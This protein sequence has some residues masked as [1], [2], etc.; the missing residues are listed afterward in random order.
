[1]RRVFLCAALALGVL[2]PA[3]AAQAA[4]GFLPGSEGFRAEAIAEGGGPEL[5]SGSHPY[6]LRLGFGLRTAGP[7][8]EGDLRDLR[9]ELPGGLIENP[10]A[11]PKCTPA[12]F[13]TPRSS[14]F[15]ESASGESCPAATQIGTIAL[16]T[17]HGGGE[18]RSFGLFNLVPAPGIAAE[19]GAAPYGVPIVFKSTV[20]A[21]AAGEYALSLEA[22]SISQ[23]LDLYSLQI[24]LWG[25]PW[26]VGH[27]G[28]RGNCLN[29]QEPSFGWAKCSVGA[30]SAQQPK[31]YLTMPTACAAPLPYTAS[32]TSWQG[33][34]DTAVSSSTDAEGN[35]APLQGCEGLS[36]DSQAVG[37]L[38]SNRASSPSGLEFVLTD[39][40]EALT[41]PKIRLPS[42]VKDAIVSLPEGVTINPSLGAGLGVCTP[43][44]YAA[45]TAFS[46]QGAGC[47]NDSKIGEFRV[48]SPLYEEA[49]GGAIYLAQSDDKASAQ[50]GAENPFDALIAVYLVAKAP[51]R[52]VLVKLAGKLEPNP[53]TGQLVATFA[54]LPQLPYTNLVINFREGNRAPLVTPNA[55]GTYA[56]VSALTPWQGAL[57][58]L[59]RNSIST[60]E[61]GPGGSPCPQGPV[62]FAPGAK[63]G[64]LN[65]NAAAS[66]P[67][68]LHL[69]R[70][71]TDR[72]ITS[73]ST[74]LPPGLLGSIAGIPYCPDQ[75][76]EAAKRK[77]GTQERESPSC[78]A[79][80]QIGHTSAGYG[81]G[82]VLTY[83]P[84]R[85]YL[86]GPYHG[87]PL[88]ITAV[89]PALV[90]PFDLGVVIVRSA[91]HVDP[92][93]AQV[94]ID[95]A[96]SDP[97]PHIIDGIPIHL[98]DVRVYIDRRQMM[99]NPTSCEPSH[100]ISTLTGSAP[101]FTNP[102]DA[103]ASVADPF[104]ASNCASLGFG[105]KLALKLKGARIGAFPVLTAIVRT[106]P[107]DANFGAATV[108]LPHTEFLAQDHID[109]VCRLGEF[110]SETCPPGSVY[111]KVSVRT[112]LLT[113]PMRGLVYLR[114]SPTGKGLPDLV[115]DLHEN[116]IRIAVV[117][118]ID[119]PHGGM[120]ARFNGLP[121]APFETFRL[122]MNGGKRGL[123]ENSTD[124]C[125]APA[126]ASVRLIGQA[127]EVK[128]GQTKLQANCGRKKK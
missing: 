56:T 21:A 116:G 19:F 59:R 5:L 85:L 119:S 40:L 72:E 58:A 126:F 94:S 95:S 118:K 101:P 87:Q 62:P 33:G 52:G 47:P 74:V 121:D 80:S 114:S 71:D 122:T 120:R 76:I 15:E 84:G 43:P 104:Q 50:P 102:I 8:T 57:G 36:F 111:G 83:A 37:A 22:Q 79:A 89:D 107:G 29:E 46:P 39:N 20:R 14:P 67:F 82:S 99:V 53:V 12:Q 44:Q 3:P 110:A 16:H 34:A 18:V 65:S 78:P 125:V 28:Q 88:S 41:Q 124:L 92:Y 4:F 128:A 45:E 63:A 54:N 35:P 112:P 25:T 75:A 81:V 6:E 31:P 106:R 103:T 115:A 90:G 61:A 17:S 60:I 9:L 97:I 42:Q 55:C 10:D 100:V 24:A 93:S 109:T 27:N 117:G 13:T 49:L 1:M 91:I 69:T 96:G 68:Y 66:S 70:S 30:P 48:E 86:S 108:A 123:L 98:R 32:L 64:T 38:V 113:E 127:N 105:P 26:G 51:G 73:Y 7:Y 2:G 77:T 23:H 11:L